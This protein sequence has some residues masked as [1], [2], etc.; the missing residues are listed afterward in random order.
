MS[1]FARTSGQEALTLAPKPKTSQT[2]LV[3]VNSRDR[4][5][6]AANQTTNSFRF[7]FQRPI[8]DIQTVELLAG[9]VPTPLPLTTSNNAFTVVEGSARNTITLAPAFYT[10]TTLAAA[11]QTALN[12]MPGKANTYTAA[13]DATGAYL[14]VTRATGTTSFTF[15]FA[16][17]APADT[18]QAVNTPSTAL[19]FASADYTHVNGVIQAPFPMDPVMSRIYLYIDFES[20]LSLSAIERGTGRRSPFG[21]IYFDQTTNGYKFL[22]K[23]TIQQTL[24]KLAQPLPRLQSL[25]IDFRDEFYHPINFGGRELTLLLQFTGLVA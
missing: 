1:G 23:E 8:K 21:V 17:G 18:T 4:N 19:G 2:I 12:A 13:L 16:S 24:Y 25:Q 22:N 11:L 3:E 5:S 15:L 9:T 10:N 20:T 14:V 7:T 6:S